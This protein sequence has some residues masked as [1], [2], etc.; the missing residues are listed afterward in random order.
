MFIHEVAET[1]NKKNQLKAGIYQGNC[2][3]YSEQET[4]T[5]LFLFE[6]GLKAKDDIT[7]AEV[8]IADENGDL[9]F[10]DFMQLPDDSWRDSYGK[11][12]DTLG[13]L[14][15]AEVLHFELI[16]RIDIE[17]KIIEETV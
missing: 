16:E 14:L 6:Y 17:D 11:K 13:E 2:T 4:Q 9:F 5:K 7:V 10:R 8:L 15:P 3:L 1:K 12:A